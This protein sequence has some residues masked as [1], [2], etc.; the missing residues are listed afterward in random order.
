MRLKDSPFSKKCSLQ[1]GEK[2]VDFSTPKIMGVLNM[3]PDSFFDG[4]KNSSFE[5]AVNQAEKMIKEGA[6]FID[7]GGYSSR[8]GASEVSIKEEI[9]RTVPIVKA[10][11]EK[12][13]QI[14][15][16]IDTFRKSVAEENLKAGATWVNDISA[17]NLDKEMIP[18][19]K[20]NQIPYI[21]MHMRG[22]PK[23][24]QNNC[25]Y[26]HLTNEVLSELIYS[27]RELN[28]DHPLILDPGFGF[29]KTLD[30][31]YELLDNL[32]LFSKL[33]QPFLVGVSRKSLIYKVLDGGPQDALNGTSVLN[34]V[35]LMKGA[36][37]LRVHDVK[38]AKECLRLL[39][40]L[41]DS[42]LI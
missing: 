2:I 37:I 42:S 18:W 28:A 33:R 22:N 27:I 8:P 7:I 24:M 19:V 25:T 23:T 35:G 3:T 31:N 38:E 16:S 36:S 1:I 32:E 39:L 29:S 14:F 41:R 20:A 13:P 21:A 11:H 4:G 5:T 26:S 10:I 12:F 30:Q 9:N 15:I 34:T 6:D 40:K 17:G